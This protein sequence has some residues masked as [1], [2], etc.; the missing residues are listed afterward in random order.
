MQNELTLCG[1]LVAVMAFFMVLGMVG[2][3]KEKKEQK[4]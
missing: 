4:K 3:Q 2:I 1:I